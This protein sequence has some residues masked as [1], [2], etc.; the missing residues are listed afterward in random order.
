MAKEHSVN[1]TLLHCKEIR[2]QLFF[3]H[4]IVHVPHRPLTVTY[5]HPGTVADGSRKIGLGGLY[6]RF[7]ILA[8]A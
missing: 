2:F 1:R 6:G 4:D 8:H 7:K 5:F 3:Q